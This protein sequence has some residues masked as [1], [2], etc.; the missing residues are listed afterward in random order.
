M[1]SGYR[2]VPDPG[3][4]LRLHLNE[5]TSGCSPAA[6]AAL[7]ALG[8]IDA[9]VYPD[10]TAVNAETAA[11]FGVP[12][13]WLL[14]TNG[15]DEGLQLVSWAALGGRDRRD[16]ADAVVVEPAF[17]M[18]AACAAAAGG[19][20][21]AVA[22][23]PDFTFPIDAV[24]AAITPDTRLVFLTSPNNPTGQ[25]MSRAEIHRVAAAAAHAL[26]LVDEAYAEFG[27]DSLM[28][29]GGLDAPTN[30]IVGRTFAK[31][32]GLAALRIGALV[33]PPDTLAPI[34]RLALPYRLNVAAVAALRAALRDR[35]HVERCLRETA[36][37]KRLLYAACD[38]LGFQYWRS[39][40]NFV[41]VRVG[42]RAQTLV[43]GLARRRIFIRDR[44]SEPGCAGCVRITAGLVE[45]TQAC[46]T[47]MEEIL[48]G[49]Q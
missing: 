33:A 9:A 10:Y 43:E 14:L 34:R 16:P 5:N 1:T 7:R 40:A 15:L 37:S 12:V 4:G 6:L 46:I 11:H 13:D 17:D 49:A 27:N 26:V 18:Y 20:V 29:A 2:T 39:A 30:V 23:R 25:V 45:H 19:R 41:L 48:C 21:V 44:S 32:H 3:E 36:E 28:G 24:L 31:A 42:P 35:T 22:P 47:A 38:R 8:E